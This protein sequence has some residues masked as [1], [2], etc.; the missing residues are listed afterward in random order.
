LFVAGINVSLRLNRP[1]SA[2]KSVVLFGLKAS[3][4]MIYLWET[5]KEAASIAA[6]REAPLVECGCDTRHPVGVIPLPRVYVV[7]DNADSSLGAIAHPECA[8]PQTC[9]SLCYPRPKGRGTQNRRFWY[10]K[11]KDFLCI[12]LLVTDESAEQQKSLIFVFQK[13]RGIFVN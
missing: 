5:S 11:I 2:E 3:Y 6:P 4:N 9:R 12:T 13:C 8:I 1:S 10:Q 7:T